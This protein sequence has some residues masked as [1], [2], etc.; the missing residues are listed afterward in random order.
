MLEWIRFGLVALFFAAGLIVLFISIFG[1]YRFGYS[2]N[3]MHSAAMCDT[4]VLML[5]ITGLIIASGINIL[6]LKFLF[7]VIIQWCTSPVV[8]HIFVKTKLLT[9]KNLCEHC[10]L[11][12]DD[13]NLHKSETEKE[14]NE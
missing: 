13:E 6:S 11:H 10:E 2:L 7:I 12:L 1:T 3:R 8:S 14:E 5:F 4:L 9:D